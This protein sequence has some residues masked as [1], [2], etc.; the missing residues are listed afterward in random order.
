MKETLSGQSVSDFIP[1]CSA[2]IPT[3]F[4]GKHLC[5]DL[6]PAFCGLF[7][8]LSCGRSVAFLLKMQPLDDPKINRIINYSQ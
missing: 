8:G 1:V 7:C 4:R 3:C 2:Y 5:C 6:F